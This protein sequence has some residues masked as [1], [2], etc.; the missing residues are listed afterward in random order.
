MVFCLSSDKIQVVAI[1]YFTINL[2]SLIRAQMELNMDL[3]SQTE[4]KGKIET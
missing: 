1:L 3:K 4:K 2:L